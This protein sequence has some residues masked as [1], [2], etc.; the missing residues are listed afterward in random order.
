MRGALGESL[1]LSFRRLCRVRLACRDEQSNKYEYT[2][3]LL[4]SESLEIIS[5]YEY[6]SVLCSVSQVGT[7]AIQIEK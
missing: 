2:I 3:R 1:A 4:F 5:F 6:L 7:N